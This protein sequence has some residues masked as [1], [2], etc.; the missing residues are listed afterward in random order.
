MN[1]IDPKIWGKSAWDTI[2]YFII[3]Y[4]PTEVQKTNMRNFILIFGEMLPCNTCQNNYFENLK[5]FNF[6]DETLENKKN[7]IDLF[8]DIKNDISQQNKKNE[9]TTFEQILRDHS[10]DTKN[11]NYHSEILKKSTWDTIFYF[12]MAYPDLPNMEHKKNMKNFILILA[13]ILLR[14]EFK[15]NYFEILKKL[16]FSDKTLENRKNVVELFI[17]IKKNINKNKELNYGKILNKY[18][19]YKNEE[20]YSLEII[21]FVILFIL[22]LLIIM[23]Y[24]FKKKL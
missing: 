7:V 14:N 18:F 15:N 8:I 9:K 3:E 12:T 16:N 22:L 11:K 17:N 6:S 24:L 13:P 5:K 19:Y 1:N 20:N 2:F 10:P 23:Y 21:I 4:N